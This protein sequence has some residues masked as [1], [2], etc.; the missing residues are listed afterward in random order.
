MNRGPLPNHNIR[1][2]FATAQRSSATTPNTTYI[3]RGLTIRNT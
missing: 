2:H 3:Q 1:N